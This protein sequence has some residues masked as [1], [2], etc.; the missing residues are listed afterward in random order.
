MTS[1]SFRIVRIYHWCPFQTVYQFAYQISVVNYQ[2]DQLNYGISAQN[3]R[4]DYQI[5][6]PDE[7]IDC[8]FFALDE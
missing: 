1:Y 3:Y 5:S 8:Q 2:I 7:Q 4:I 6:V